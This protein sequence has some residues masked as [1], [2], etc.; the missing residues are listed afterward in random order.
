MPVIAQLRQR[1]WPQPGKAVLSIS[2]PKNS[3]PNPA[4]AMPSPARRVPAP[5]ELECHANA[6]KGQGKG[7][8]F[9][10]EANQATS[11]PRDRGA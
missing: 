7:I 10:F 2:I 5:S 11:Q 8:N 6:N 9:H 4:S 1:F 3:T